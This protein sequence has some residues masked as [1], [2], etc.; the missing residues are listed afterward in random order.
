L[1]EVIPNRAERCIDL[2]KHKSW[3]Y[4][5]WYC[6]KDSGDILQVA[7]KQRGEQH[8]LVRECASRA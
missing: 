8:F 1:D 6:F 4:L 7:A 2:N 3:T 5:A